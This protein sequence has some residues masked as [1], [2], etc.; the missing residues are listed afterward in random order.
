MP[1]KLSQLDPAAALDGSEAVPLVQAGATRRTTVAALRAGLAASAHAHGAGDVAGLAAVAYSGDWADVLGRPAVPAL[2]DEPPAALAG[3]AAAGAAAAAA[4][5]DH[6]HPLPSLAALGLPDDRLWQ[7]G[8]YKH[9]ARATP[10]PGWVFADGRTIGADGSGASARAHADAAALFALLWADYPQG[11]LAVSGGR[12]ASAAADFAAGKT[13]ALPDLRG[14]ILVGRDDMG[15]AAAARVTASG[16][17]NPGIAATQLGAS[18]GADR[19]ALAATE[20][21]AHVH[22]HD[23]LI[24]T[25]AGTH[26]WEVSGGGNAAASLSS[27]TTTAGGGQAHPQM[28][29]VLVCN[30]LIRL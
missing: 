29:P 1:V 24:Y 10:P 9:T 27:V 13:I 14:R 16:A 20:M 26:N 19:H 8:D 25:G 7:T 23:G 18:G 11:V 28:P 12:G 5:A 3:A 4:R 17:G 6:A 2:S 30:V 21:P 22:G 15:G